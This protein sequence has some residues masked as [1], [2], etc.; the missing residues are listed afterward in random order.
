MVKRPEAKPSS[1]SGMAKFV[2]SPTQAALTKTLAE[3]MRVLPGAQSRKTFGYPA[4]FIDGKMFAGLYDDY[5]ILRLSPDDLAAFL[6]IEGARPFE[7]MPGRSMG[8]YAVVPPSILNSAQA[9]TEWTG[10]AF[11]YAKSLPAKKPK[12]KKA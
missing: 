7:P 2:N 1:D 5:L 9:L 4:S 6:K 3:T 11:D 12:K 10:K 8:G